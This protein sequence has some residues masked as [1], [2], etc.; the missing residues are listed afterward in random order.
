MAENETG[1]R[2]PMRLSGED[3][4]CERGGRMLFAG[5]SFTLDAGEAVLIEGPNGSGKTTLIRAIAGLGRF[6][7]GKVT[8]AGGKDGA[9][10]DEQAHY[11]GHADAVKPQLTVTEN[12]SFWGQYLGGGD[13]KAA[14]DAFNLHAIADLPAQ[15]LSAGQRRKL[16]LSRLL[17]VPRAIWLLDE[18][19]VSLDRAAQQTLAALMA[20]HVADGGI[21]LASTHMELGTVFS[22]NLRL[23][24][25]AAA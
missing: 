7:R 14:L 20:A 10:L 23:G 6:A 12:L 9:E 19:S 8:V 18:P 5:V 2:R 1:N 17:L 11:V 16:A 22:K 13:L 15:Y 3:L 21:L 25:V 4:A 24:V